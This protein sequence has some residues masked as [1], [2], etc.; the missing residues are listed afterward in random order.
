M[1]LFFFLREDLKNSSAVYTANNYSSGRDHPP[2][3]GSLLSCKSAELAKTRNNPSSLS[4]LKI[5]Q[6]NPFVQSFSSSTHINATISQPLQTRSPRSPN[7]DEKCPHEKQVTGLGSHEVPWQ[8][9]VRNPCPIPVC[10]ECLPYPPGA[11]EGSP[12]FR[13]PGDSWVLCAMLQENHC[14]M[15]SLM[16]ECF[17]ADLF[18]QHIMKSHQLKDH[19]K[20]HKGKSL[21]KQSRASGCTFTAVFPLILPPSFCQ[22]VKVEHFFIQKMPWPWSCAAVKHAHDPWSLLLC[23]FSPLSWENSIIQRIFFNQLLHAYRQGQAWKRLLHSLPLM[24]DEHHFQ[25]PLTCHTLRHASPSFNNK[26]R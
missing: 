18:V 26:A 3:S 9:W 21:H 8:S 6:N 14:G 16:T 11:A 25:I 12:G 2:P 15:E 20:I 17:R 24:K 1:L 5:L 19:N 7:T 4:A 23:F 22:E 10:H 13:I